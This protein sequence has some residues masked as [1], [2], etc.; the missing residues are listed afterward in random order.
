MNERDGSLKAADHPPI[1]FPEADWQFVCER[2]A[3]LGL[4]ELAPHRLAFE[5]LYGHLVGVNNWLNLTRITEPR[6][7]LVRHLLDSWTAL[8]DPRLQH[9]SEGAPCVDLGSGG[10]YPGLPLALATPR[11]PWVL[12]DSRQRKVNFLAEAAGLVDARA[13]A[14]CFRGREAKRAA[15][16][17]YRRCQLVVS[18]AAAAVDK[19]LI[20]CVELL[21]HKGHLI[22]FQG[23]GYD[24]A[25]H[26]RALN[27]AE[28][29]GYRFVTITG[30]Q[31][32]PEAPER[33]LITFQRD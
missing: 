9:L 13:S 20:E 12:V 8:G 7:F 23:P 27:V 5:A 17:L 1:S 19:L 28:Q 3:A 25:A 15:P 32:L 29:K 18:R 26:E 22:A 31:L 11:V 2:A 16:Q 14:A 4:P 10:G 33:M 6:E 30:L 21:A 24:E